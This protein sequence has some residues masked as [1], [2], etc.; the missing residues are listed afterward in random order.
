MRGIKLPPPATTTIIMYY[1]ILLGNI[2]QRKYQ[3]VMYT[4]RADD[5]TSDY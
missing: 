3:K 2:V 4:L 1:T 5:I